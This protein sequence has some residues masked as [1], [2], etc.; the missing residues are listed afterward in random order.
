MVPWL[1]KSADAATGAN[2]DLRDALRVSF[3]NFL[4]ISNFS[5]RGTDPEPEKMKL[6]CPGD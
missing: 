5:R 1:R 2:K 4:L 3:M 6:Q